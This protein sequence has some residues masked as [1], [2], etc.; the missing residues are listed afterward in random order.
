[1]AGTISSSC[2]LSVNH[3]S[4]Q[5]QLNPGQ[6]VIT[7]AV[8][9]GPSPGC[10]I[11]A[12]DADTE[13]D[14]SELATLGVIQVTNLDEENY[15]DFGPDDGEGALKPA[16]RIEAGETWQFRLVPGVTYFARADTADCAVLFSAFND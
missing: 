8:A 5:Q 7:Q 4:L 13:I 9:R 11:V 16:M 1:M 15:V 3:G 2:V 12:D 14:F 6:K 10:V